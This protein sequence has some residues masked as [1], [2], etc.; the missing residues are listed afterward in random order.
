MITTPHL[1]AFCLYAESFF[2][3]FLIKIILLISG[4][5]AAYQPP[6]KPHKN[7]EPCALYTT[8]FFSKIIIFTVW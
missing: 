6:L 7:I 3:F 2:F 1:D 8:F 5:K 4:G